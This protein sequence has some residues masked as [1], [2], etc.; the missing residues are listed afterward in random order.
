V[1][2]PQRVTLPLPGHP[3]I[4]LEAGTFDDLIATGE[5]LVR[6]AR[7]AKGEANQAAAPFVRQTTEWV[8]A[9]KAIGRILAAGNRNDGWQI[10]FAHPDSSVDCENGMRANG[11]VE[12]GMVEVVR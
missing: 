10:V 6:L 2:E 3:G 12:D 11:R 4:V 5:Q 7:K 9:S 8:P 1:T